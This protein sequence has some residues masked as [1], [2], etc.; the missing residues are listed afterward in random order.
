[1]CTDLQCFYFICSTGSAFWSR[2]ANYHYQCS[3]FVAQINEGFSDIFVRLLILIF[4]LC[5]F[6]EKYSAIFVD[7]YNLCCVKHLSSHDSGTSEIIWLNSW[8]YSLQRHLC[9][10]KRKEA[11]SQSQ[12]FGSFNCTFYLYFAFKLDHLCPHIFICFN[13]SFS[14]IFAFYLHLRY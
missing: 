2:F 13:F 12:H 6:K 11:F 4:R 1:M 14:F 3:W 5:K 7:S 10:Y 8:L 9:Q